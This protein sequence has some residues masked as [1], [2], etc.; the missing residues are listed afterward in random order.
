LEFVKECYASI[1]KRLPRRDFPVGNHETIVAFNLIIFFLWGL[2]QK[3][4]MAKEYPEYGKLFARMSNKEAVSE[5]DK[6][7]KHALLYNPEE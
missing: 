4:T 5:V 7:D 2:E 6:Y 1:D 3:I